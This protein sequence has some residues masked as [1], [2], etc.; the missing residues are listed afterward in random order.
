MEALYENNK[1]KFIAFALASALITVGYS[2]AVSADSV[3]STAKTAT[4]NPTM[5]I[6]PRSNVEF[7][8]GSTVNGWYFWMN[9]GP[10]TIF[11]NK[12]AGE[13]RTIQTQGTISYMLGVIAS[14]WGTSWHP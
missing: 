13:Y 9:F 2:T 1:T 5:T 11:R 8:G 14:G 3:T 6:T 12:Y 7:Q 4:T 10:Y